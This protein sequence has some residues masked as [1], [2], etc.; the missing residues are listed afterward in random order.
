MLFACKD[1]C[2]CCGADGPD[3]ISYN[4]GG[5]SGSFSGSVRGDFLEGVKGD[6]EI[7]IG[8]EG[9]MTGRDLDT[10]DKD[11]GGLTGLQDCSF[12]LDANQFPG[13]DKRKRHT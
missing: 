11:M 5:T 7:F 9:G 3:T 8:V 10:N 2:G 1:T 4:S 6:L 12:S 13:D